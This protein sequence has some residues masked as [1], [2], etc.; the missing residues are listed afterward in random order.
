MQD[1]YEAHGEPLGAEEVKLVKE[2]YEWPDD[3]KFLV[4]DGVYQHF[5]DGIGKRGGDAHAQWV[6]LWGDYKAK[7]P[8]LAK[9][10]ELMQKRE[11]PEG[12]DKNL[13][14][15]PADAKGMA[16]R[17]SSGK[18]G[19]HAGEEYSVADRRLGGSGEIEQNQPGISGCGR[20]SSRRVQGTEF[21]LRRSRTR[22]GRSDEWNGAHKAAAIWRNVFQFQRLREAGD[23]PWSADG[24]AGHLCI[25]A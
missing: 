25:H 11:L 24:A 7:F 2:N 14:V 13:P 18:N 12:W 1:S 9:Q 6:K 19:E 17:E 8:E 15:F 21:A 16:S 10:L 4:P 23:P 22:H 20:F 5:N 3:A